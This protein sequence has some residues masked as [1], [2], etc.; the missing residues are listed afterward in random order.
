M[1]VIINDF[2]VN[3]QPANQEQASPAN[4][5]QPQPAPLAPRLTPEDIR[6][7]MRRQMLRQLRL[8]AH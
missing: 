8:R 5:T 1:P 6:Q 7:I 2:E 3:L 4:G